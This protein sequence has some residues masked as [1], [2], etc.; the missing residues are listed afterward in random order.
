MDEGNGAGSEHIHSRQEN[1]PPTGKKIGVEFCTV[2]HEK[3]VENLDEKLFYH[4][5][6]LIRQ[7][8]RI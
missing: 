7:P 8:G 3:N 1:N 5:I 6:V 4:K 2:S